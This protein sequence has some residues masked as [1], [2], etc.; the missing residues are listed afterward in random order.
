MKIQLSK[1]RNKLLNYL[2]EKKKVF[3]F[4]SKLYFCSFSQAPLE[5]LRVELYSINMSDYEQHH[6]DKEL[7]KQAGK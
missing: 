7:L 4:I 2:F 3:L 5:T 1:L 6:Y